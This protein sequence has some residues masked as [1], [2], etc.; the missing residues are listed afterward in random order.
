MGWKFFMFGEIFKCICE[1]NKFRTDKEA[2]IAIYKLAVEDTSNVD[3]LHLSSTDSSN[4]KGFVDIPK[5]TKLFNW[6]KNKE[7][8]MT[9]IVERLPNSGID[10]KS[11]SVDIKSMLS[12]ERTF[13]PKIDNISVKSYFDKK[14]FQDDVHFIAYVLWLTLFEITNSFN[15]LS[16]DF[17]DFFDKQISTYKSE[18]TELENQI[19]SLN[20]TLGQTKNESQRDSKEI[21]QLKPKIEKLTVEF[22]N[23]QKENQKLKKELQSQQRKN[24]TLLANNTNFEKME[25]ENRLLSQEVIELKKTLQESI[26]ESQKQNDKSK[27]L[28]KSLERKNEILSDE[29]SNIKASSDTDKENTNAVESELKKLRFE[30]NRKAR[31]IDEKDKYLKALNESRLKDQG[32]LKEAKKKL[33]ETTVAKDHLIKQLD[34]MQKTLEETIAYEEKFNKQNLA[35]KEVRKLYQHSLISATNKFVSFLRGVKF[36][37]EQN[38]YNETQVKQFLNYH[39]N[40]VLNLSQNF[41]VYNKGADYKY[42]KNY[43]SYHNWSQENFERSFSGCSEHEVHLIINFIYVFKSLVVDSGLA[44]YEL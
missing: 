43:K 27:E 19:N 28:I 9:N 15:K 30:N 22:N 35:N 21:N 16:K 5:K 8:T 44:L 32:E 18:N 31:E 26:K 14:T 17:F 7:K 34:G 4:S 6:C 13:F 33:G 29:L 2:L 11:L 42:D 41:D 3:S 12:N 24:Q 36:T 23:S 38:G 1:Q 10:I 39:I 37:K 20:Q 40:D 25:K